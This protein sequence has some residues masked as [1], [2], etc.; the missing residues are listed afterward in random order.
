M[1]TELAFTRFCITQEVVLRATDDGGKTIRNLN[2]VEL[3][4]VKSALVN[5]G[6]NIYGKPSPTFSFSL[7]WKSN[8]SKT[9]WVAKF[10]QYSFKIRREEAVLEEEIWYQVYLFD[11]NLKEKETIGVHAWLDGAK[12][13]VEGWIKLQIDIMGK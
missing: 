13:I 5:A 3:D 2:E 8:D 12:D 9:E 7:K 6:F 1:K 10:F 11:E 4:K